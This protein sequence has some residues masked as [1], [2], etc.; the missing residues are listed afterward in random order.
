MEV[1]AWCAG[2]TSCGGGVPDTL[3]DIKMIR[4]KLQAFGR[5]IRYA[6]PAL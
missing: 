5:L 4:I 3:I 6:W 2:G 1:F